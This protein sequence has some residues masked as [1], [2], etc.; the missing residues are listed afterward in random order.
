MKFI[1]KFILPL[2]LL[3]H[4]AAAH[5]HGNI[6]IYWGQNG[7]E[8]RLNETCATG[9]YSFVNIAFLNV[10]GAGQTP[11][12]NLAGHCTPA[13]QNCVFLADEIKYCQS[14]KVK[15]L[16]SIG[17]GI[18]T[19]NLTSDTDADNVAEYLWNYFL[20]GKHN[21]TFRPLGAAVLDGVDLDIEQGSPAFYPRLVKKL[22]S[23]STRER[24]V[25]IAGA[26]QCPFPDE[27]LAPAINTRLFDYVWV[28]FYN[29]APCQFN[30]SADNLLKSWSG[31]ASYL[32]KYS[33]NTKLF[34][35]LPAAPEAAGSGYIPPEILTT[36]IIPKINCS[37]NYGGVMLWSKY[38]DEKNDNYSDKILKSL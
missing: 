20:A 4:T 11:Q 34:L 36:V 15:V 10:F 7:F 38:W 25:Y 28:Q 30:G 23:H 37:R 24:K 13:S 27:K 8:S 16:L 19:Y 26:P 31:W 17:G 29:N 2:L 14:K 3:L 21:S 35:G 33:K 18:G 1:L 5:R 12:L 32:D 22:T 9:R 6:S